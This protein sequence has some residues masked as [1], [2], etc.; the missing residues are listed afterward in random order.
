MGDHCVKE[1]CV[2]G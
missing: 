1:L 2:L